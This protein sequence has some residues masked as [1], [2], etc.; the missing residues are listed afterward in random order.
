MWWAGLGAAGP[1]DLWALQ[2]WFGAIPWVVGGFSQL[3]KELGC[4]REAE[5]RGA[6]LSLPLLSPSSV[7]DYPKAGPERARGE[8]EAADEE[9]EE[10]EE[11]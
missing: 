6:E 5:G 9:E 3:G 7:Q 11:S 2:G 1:C 10:E 4:G 8:S